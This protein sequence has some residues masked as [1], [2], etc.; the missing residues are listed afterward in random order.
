ME[1][2]KKQISGTGLMGYIAQMMGEKP[3]NGMLVLPKTFG[4][5]F[6]KFYDLGP[7]IKLTVSQ[8]EL[9]ENFTLK[10]S[11]VKG[12]QNIVTFSFRNLL[13]EKKS[14]A[15]TVLNSSLLSSV[16]VS[17]ADIDI[18]V[19]TPAKT[20]GNNILITVH[21][22]LLKDLLNKK[23]GDSL[24]HTI[25]SSNE[26]YLYEE[27][28]STEM[29]HLASRIFE[30]TVQEQLVDFYYKLKAEE[31]IYLFF[32]EL[33][34][35]EKSANYPLNAE[36]AK[37]MY[38]IRDKIIAD[39]SMPPN[40]YELTLF[41]NMSE[42][43][44]NRLFKQIFGNTVYNYY[45]SLRMEMAAYFIKEEKLSVSEVGYKM[46]FSNLSH[47]TRLFEKHIGLKPKKYS[48]Q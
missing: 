41:S 24:L 18:E 12:A 30:A 42:S 21:V 19:F 13:L 36:D 31:L 20:K 17:S 7:L 14:N 23:E 48:L 28:V 26:P 43:K 10:K 9:K 45:Q 4:D 32:A 1:F 3:Q 11:G 35:R 47:F 27:I 5:G 8:Y 40:I 34:K 6:I 29:Q 38:L 16:Q 15:P 2:K 22:D 37:M 44:M 33:L 25:I 39:L 46:G